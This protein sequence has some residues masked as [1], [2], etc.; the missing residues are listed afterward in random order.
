MT[1]SSLWKRSRRPAAIYPLAL[2]IFI[3]MNAAKA[4]RDP[5]MPP[6]NVLCDTPAKTALVPRLRG[7]IGKEGDYRAWL[8]T[9]GGQGQLWAQQQWPTPRWLLQRVTAF[10]IRLQSATRCPPLIINL[11]G[12]LYE[13]EPS[14][15]RN[16]SSGTGQAAVR[17]PDAAF[18]GF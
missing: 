9:S 11:Q 4:A 3:C 12:S 10:S 14:V 7:I 2:L 16:A 8:V 13:T 17:Q 18:A 6:E 1:A 15:N 5:F